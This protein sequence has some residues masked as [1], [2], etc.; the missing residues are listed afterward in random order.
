MPPR[1]LISILK[2]RP[3]PRSQLVIPKRVA[4]IK[5]HLV[6]GVLRMLSYL[7]KIDLKVYKHLTSC[8]VVLRRTL[9]VSVRNNR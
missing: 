3:K 2:P 4:V 5:C 9:V 6:H 8:R 7:I 1:R